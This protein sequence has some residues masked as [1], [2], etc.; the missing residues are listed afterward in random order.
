MERGMRS[1]EAMR[2]GT[3]AEGGSGHTI[4][5]LLAS[6]QFSTR[7]CARCA[8]LLVSEWYYDMNNTGAHNVEALRCVQ[9]GYRVDPVILQNQILPPVESQFV[10]P[11]R[12]KYSAKAVM[13]SELT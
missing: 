6:E 3:L 1:R 9:C 11:V 2:E 8:G 12:H 13:V 7:S 10:R 4:R 5:S